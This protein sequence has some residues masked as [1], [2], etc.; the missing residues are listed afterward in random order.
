MGGG[1]VEMRDSYFQDCDSCG[2][3][4]SKDCPHLGDTGLSDCWHPEGTVLIWTEVAHIRN[5]VRD[6]WVWTKI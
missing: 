3:R 4:D 6:G 5:E 1:Q 2:G